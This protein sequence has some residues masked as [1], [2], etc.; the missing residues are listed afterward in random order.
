MRTKVS[1][2]EFAA[3]RR[4]APRSHSLTWRKW[5]L[6]T[7]ETRRAGLEFELE[8]YA[9]RRGANFTGSFKDGRLADRRRA[10]NKE[11]EG[12][13]DSRWKTRVSWAENFSGGKGPAFTKK[14]ELPRPPPP[15]GELDRSPYRS[16]SLSTSGTLVF[17]S[18]LTSAPQRKE[19]V[20]A[21]ARTRSQPRGSSLGG[22][23]RGSTEADVERWEYKIL[24]P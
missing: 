4:F 21:D 22:R 20:S 16:S 13:G 19:G 8:E 9:F 1:A 17:S 14:L 15:A 11:D 3:L 10:Y 6:W 2:V 12:A 24:R 7:V 5:R 18:T 23:G